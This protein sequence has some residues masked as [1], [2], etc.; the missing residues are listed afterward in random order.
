[1]AKLVGKHLGL[2]ISFL[3]LLFSS[4]AYC[5]CITDLGPYENH[6]GWAIFPFKNSCDENAVV[7]LCVKSWPPGSSEPVYNSY[8]GVVNAGS[9]V[10]LTDGM[11]RTFDSY[12]WQENSPQ[13]CPFE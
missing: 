8:G 7:S 3:A 5:T 12:R 11:W 4:S 10:D 6:Q 13:A 9:R 1:M 2:Q